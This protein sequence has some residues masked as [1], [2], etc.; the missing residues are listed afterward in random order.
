MLVGVSGVQRLV[1]CDGGVRIE[2]SAL[3]VEALAQDRRD[4]AGPMPLVA[5]G[6]FANARDGLPGDAKLRG[7]HW[8]GAPTTPVVGDD[9]AEASSP[10]PQ[11]PRF[12]CG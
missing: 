10:R 3:A 8:A 7:R 11:F 1:A 6:E 9:P 12:Q 5:L 4:A 2:D